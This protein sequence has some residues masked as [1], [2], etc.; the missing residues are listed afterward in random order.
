MWIIK[1]IKIKCFYPSRILKEHWS[2]YSYFLFTNTAQRG[3]VSIYTH[4]IR[5]SK[6]FSY[7]ITLPNTFYFAQTVANDVLYKRIVY[8][9]HNNTGANDVLYKCIVYVLHNN[10]VA[11][12]V[13]CKC[14]VYILH[15]NTHLSGNLREYRWIKL[16]CFSSC[17]TNE[18]TGK[19]SNKD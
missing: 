4:R 16:L 19:C 1:I 7:I 18:K 2:I 17:W 5:N 9:L 10:T 3:L 13:L 11:N 15:N 6:Y 8:V 12:D 14:I